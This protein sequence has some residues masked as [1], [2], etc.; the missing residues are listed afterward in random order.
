MRKSSPSRII[1]DPMEKLGVIDSNIYIYGQFIEHV[2]T[3]IYDGLWAEMLHNRR[4]EAMDYSLNGVSDGWYPIGSSNNVT[5]SHRAGA[6]ARATFFLHSV[7]RKH[8]SETMPL[9]IKDLCH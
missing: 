4:F 3:C 8:Q 2:G 9:Y 7:C 5:F 1:V 6:R